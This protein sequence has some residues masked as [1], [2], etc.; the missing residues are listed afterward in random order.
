MCFHYSR[1]RNLQ[2]FT[3]CDSIAAPSTGGRVV[4]EQVIKVLPRLHFLE[5]IGLRADLFQRR[6]KEFTRFHRNAKRALW[7]NHHSIAEVRELVK[8]QQRSFSKF[9]H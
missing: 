5:P 2:Q 8:S 1:F 3:T 4:I 6:K 7:E 9:S